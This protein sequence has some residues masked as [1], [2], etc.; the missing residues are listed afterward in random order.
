MF[1]SPARQKQ[2]DRAELRPD[3]TKHA[4][5]QRHL[6]SATTSTTFTYPSQKNPSP[7]AICGLAR[8]LLET[9]ERGYG[10]ALFYRRSWKAY[11]VILG[12]FGIVLPW[13]AM[14]GWWELFCGLTGVLCGMLLRDIGWVRAIRKNWPFSDKVTDW[15]KVRRMAEGKLEDEVGSEMKG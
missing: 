14:E 2:R 9:R 10:F 1:W 5:N 3:P 12:Y 11:L 15:E 13:M 4:P 7:H 6:T 8:R